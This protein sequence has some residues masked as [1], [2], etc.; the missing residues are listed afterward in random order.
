MNKWSILVAGHKADK[1]AELESEGHTRL[2]K[3]ARRM[4]R[5]EAPALDYINC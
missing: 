5:P 4:E 2:R 3:L 1:R